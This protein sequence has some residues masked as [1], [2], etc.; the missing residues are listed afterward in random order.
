MIKSYHQ[1]SN[2]A[3]SA[4]PEQD[5]VRIAEYFLERVSQQ[6]SLLY[7]SLQEA[8]NG[9]TRAYSIYDKLCND[10]QLFIFDDN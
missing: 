9:G 6:L 4:G 8:Y 7:P 2:D 1:S 5:K 3:S 10:G